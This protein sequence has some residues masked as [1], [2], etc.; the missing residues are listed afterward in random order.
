[1]YNL[2]KKILFKLDA[3]K[4]H[5]LTINLAHLLPAISPLLGRNSSDKFS[6]K[7]ANNTWSFPVGLA[8]GLDKNAYAFDFF[9]GLGFGAVE[10]GTVTPKPQTGNDKPR[11]FRYIEEESIRNCMGFNNQG[12]SGLLEN[13][14]TITTRNIP[15][16]INIGKNK[17]TND[18][19]A[20]EDYAVLYHALNNKCDYIVINVSSP[21]TPGLREHQ[22]KDGLE[23]ILKKLD[24]KNEV[25]LFVKIA[26]D[27]ELSSITD[28]CEL[29]KKYGL[30]GIVA[31]NTTI[32]PERGIG[33]VSGQLLYN[34]ADLIRKRCIEVLKEDPQRNLIGV[35]GFSSFEQ[36]KNYWQSG[37]RALQIYSSF[38]FQ[39][40]E[41]LKN[42]QRRLLNDFEEYQVKNFE[43][44]LEAIRKE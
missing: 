13:L 36:M 9:Q 14:K 33:G 2:L 32:M 22:T 37:G 34:K 41:I 3:E 38:I 7:V 31:T 40:P 35:G 4:A 12:L 15:L 21:N 18:D 30:T 39:G 16:G 11:L 43:E 5:D 6:L 24:Y 1:M 27:I 8:A 42:I 10:V 25:D 29:V 17:T 23:T 19:L 26:P 44:Y 20:H 28:I